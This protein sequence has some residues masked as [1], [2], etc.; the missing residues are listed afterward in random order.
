MK[1]F[2]SC[3]ILVNNSLLITVKPLLQKLGVEDECYHICSWWV[4]KR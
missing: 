4:Q 3:K 1:A 2:D